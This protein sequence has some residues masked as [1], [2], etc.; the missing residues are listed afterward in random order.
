[1]PLFGVPLRPGATQI[2]PSGET[3][4]PTHSIL[5]NG[6]Y[7]IIHRTAGLYL[8]LDY[9]NPERG[10]NVE[11]ST[12]TGNYCQLWRIQAVEDANTYT[13][14]SVRSGMMME[15]ENAG[16]ENGDN[17]RL[18]Y[19]NGSDSHQWVLKAIEQDGFVIMNKHSGLV[20]GLDESSEDDNVIQIDNT[21]NINQ[22][23][24]LK[25]VSE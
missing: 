8:N 23:W 5:E 17:I 11:L 6:T 14:S 24:E 15:V 1:M 3:Q 13:I 16:I 20:L 19:P 21:I 18:W 12:G 9:C 22:L 10:A 25:P 2:A 4:Q 7:E